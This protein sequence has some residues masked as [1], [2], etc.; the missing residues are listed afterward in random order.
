MIVFCCFARGASQCVVCSAMHDER[1]AFVRGASTATAV[2]YTLSFARTALSL[3]WLFL[4]GIVMRSI[5][6]LAM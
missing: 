4:L 6:V 3:H 2:C 1:T 5:C